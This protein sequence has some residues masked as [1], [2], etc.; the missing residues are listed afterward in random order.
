MLENSQWVVGHYL[1]LQSPAQAW[2][3]IITDRCASDYDGMSF[4]NE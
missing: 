1:S 3:V 2:A 4:Q